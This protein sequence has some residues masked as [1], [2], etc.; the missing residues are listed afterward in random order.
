MQRGGNGSKYT[1]VREIGKG[2]YGKAML[3]RAKDGKEYVMKMIDTSR[4]NWK[5]RKEAQTEVEVLSSIKH[6]YIVQYRENFMDGQHL[7]IVMDYAEGGDLFQHIQKVKRRGD[8]IPEAT[9]LKWFTQGALA[10]KYL[11]DRHTLHRDLKTQNL[12]LTANGRLKVGDFGISKVLQNTNCFAMTQIGTP[13]YLSPEICQKKPYSWGTDVWSLGCVLYELCA[14]KVP[15]EGA[16]LRQLANRICSGPAPFVPPA[17]SQEL[18]TLCLE[19]LNRDVKRR[20]SATD[21]LQR[22]IVQREIKRMLD[23]E[24]KEHAKKE[25]AKA[26]VL[27]KEEGEKPKPAEEPTNKE[28]APPVSGRDNNNLPRPAS[29]L[30]PRKDLGCVAAAPYARA[31][32]PGPYAR[33]PSPQPQQAAHPAYRAPSPNPYGARAPSP[34]P[35]VDRPFHRVPS[36]SRAASPSCYH[37][38]PSPPVAVPP[39]RGLGLPSP[40]YRGPDYGRFGG[41]AMAAGG[42]AGFNRNAGPGFRIR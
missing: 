38:A 33:A 18:K 23:E 42:G 6:P 2:S 30:G 22:P 17:Y 1:K 26:K 20:P 37:R 9:V 32:S 16:D 35:G 28:N 31:A 40:L 24:H 41:G 8:R 19:L 10:L 12:F 36:P 4:M 27:A 15:F 29:G 3:V 7:C 5:E 21:I 25:E 13:Y 14:L 39:A 34:I 11:H